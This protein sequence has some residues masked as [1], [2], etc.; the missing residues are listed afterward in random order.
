MTEKTKDMHGVGQ[1]VNNN[2][3]RWISVK[4]INL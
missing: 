4:I 1:Y 3:N 2:D